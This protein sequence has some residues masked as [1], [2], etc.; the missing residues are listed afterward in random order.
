[1]NFSP[2]SAA[3]ALLIHR[4]LQDVFA[5]RLREFYSSTAPLLAHFTKS[6]ASDSNHDASNPNVH[7][8]Q[9]SFHR[10]SGLKVRTLSGSTSDEIWP[11]LDRLLQNTFPGLR[12]R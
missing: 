12:E 11:Q 2:L 10:P 3:A 4:M 6:A 1:M 9:V 7:P 5:R 8:H